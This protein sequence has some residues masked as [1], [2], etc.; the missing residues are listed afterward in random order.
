MYIKCKGFDLVLTNIIL[1]FIIPWIF[2]IWLFQKH[3][4]IVATIAPFTAV[5][6]TKVNMILIFLD[7]YHLTPVYEHE[8]SLSTIPFDIGLYAVLASWMVYLIWKKGKPL[9]FIFLFGVLTTLIE[10]IG[11]LF[12]KVL[13]YNG[14]TLFLTFWSYFI[15]YSLVFF[16]YTFLKKLEIIREK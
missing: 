12:G 11:I 1:G 15:P 4:A 8:E 16:Y 2:G 6:A 7:F 9:L 13:Y 14:W 10:W 3:K 5:I